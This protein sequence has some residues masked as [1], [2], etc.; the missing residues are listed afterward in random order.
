MLCIW[1]ICASTSLVIFSILSPL[2][3]HIWIHSNK[4]TD[5]LHAADTE[6]P[7]ASVL[8]GCWPCHLTCPVA[9]HW[10]IPGAKVVAT[11]GNVDFACM[12]TTSFAYEI[13]QISVACGLWKT[14]ESVSWNCW[15][16]GHLSSLALSVLWWHAT[17]ENRSNSS[18]KLVSRLPGD[19]W[20]PAHDHAPNQWCGK[21]TWWPYCLLGYIADKFVVVADFLDGWGN[22]GR[23]DQPSFSSKYHVQFTAHHV[24]IVDKH[25]EHVRDDPADWSQSQFSLACH[26][27]SSYVVELS[28]WLIT[29]LS[30]TDILCFAITLCATWRRSYSG[31]RKSVV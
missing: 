14:C 8:C 1:H 25:W 16:C 3:C 9:D 4:S 22:L 11:S 19:D 17:V 28:W 24:C 29:C 30:V 12:V 15:H 6:K 23:K 2:V 21:L 20:K 10:S 7:I 5:Q 27:S 26:G 31:D 13:L 18:L